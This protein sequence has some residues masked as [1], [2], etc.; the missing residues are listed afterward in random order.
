MLEICDGV[1]RGP[2]VEQARTVLQHLLDLPIRVMNEP[3][4][5]WMAAARPEGL[6][7]G[8]VQSEASPRGPGR[9]YTLRGGAR[10]A[11]IRVTG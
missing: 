8:L 5:K 3:K 1:L 11:C 7:V 2:H 4:P 9:F 10:A 6:A